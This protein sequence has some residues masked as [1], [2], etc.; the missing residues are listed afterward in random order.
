MTSSNVTGLFLA[1][2]LA[3]PP[4]SAL[5]EF[6]PQHQAWTSLLATHVVLIDGGKASRVRYADLAK[7]RAALKTYLG[8]LAQ[9]SEQEI[10]HL[11]Y[12]PER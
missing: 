10:R 9:V 7:D 2:V 5:A 4:G 12:R 8:S 1:A 6:D 11:D 3:L